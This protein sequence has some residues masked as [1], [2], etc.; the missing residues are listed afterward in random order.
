MMIRSLIICPVNEVF[1]GNISSL[2][3]T[4]LN[5]LATVFKFQIFFLNLNFFF[6]F[7]ISS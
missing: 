2:L 5:K 6:I 4:I 7:C 1:L 3:R